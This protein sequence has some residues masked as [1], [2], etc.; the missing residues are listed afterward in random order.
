MDIR[1]AIHSSEDTH[2]IFFHRRLEK[3]STLRIPSFMSSTDETKR[4][5]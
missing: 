4:Q 1:N 5:N 2:N 3:V